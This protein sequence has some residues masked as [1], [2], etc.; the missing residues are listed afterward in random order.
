MSSTL[1]I[2]DQISLTSVVNLVWKL[3]NKRWKTA[4]PF[5]KLVF[6]GWTWTIST[7]IS[8]LVWR[9]ITWL[10]EPAWVRNAP[11]APAPDWMSTLSGCVMAYLK[12]GNLCRRFM[13]ADQPDIVRFPNGLAGGLMRDMIL[14][15]DPVTAREVF[16]EPTTAKPVTAYRVFKRLTGY[17]G[18]GD[19]LSTRSH[20]DPLYARTRVVVYEALMKRTFNCYGT[21]FLDT[22]KDLVSRIKQTDPEKIVVVDEMHR[23]ATSLI[24]RVAFDE[25]SDNLD[26]NLFDSVVWM[27]N[28]IIARPQNNGF[29]LLDKIPTPRNYELHRNQNL[30]VSTIEQM[31]ANKKRQIEK[32]FGANADDVISTL[33]RDKKNT[34]R[35]ILG[36]CSIFFFAGFDTTSNTMAMILYHLAHNRDVQT[37]CRE[38]IK[39]IIGMDRLPQIQEIHQLSYVYAVIRETLRMFP[40]VPM[41]A[42]EVT[43]RHKNGVCPRFK[44]EEAFGVQINIFG[45]HYNPKGW[46]KPTEFIPERWIDPSIDAGMDAQQRVYCP[47]ALGKRACL[48]RHFAFIEILTVL[49]LLLQNFKIE[50]SKYSAPL[51]ITEGATL[52]V[53][54]SL[55]LSFRPLT[56]N[57]EVYSATNNHQTAKYTRKEVACHNSQD[58]A[59]LIIDG[60][61][62]DVTKYVNIQGNGAHPGGNEILIGLAGCDATADFDFISHSKRAIKMLASYKIGVLV[63]E[64]GTPIKEDNTKRTDRPR[65]RVR[66]TVSVHQDTFDDPAPLRNHS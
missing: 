51:K 44:E 33:L 49:T 61:V 28:D 41:V 11:L 7:W 21:A 63:D 19:F 54:R 37:K 64:D 12:P 42:R 24:T 13:R 46:N 14:V 2:S 1:V 53:D 18:T 4:H 31:I 16:T 29:K 36:I 55:L 32:G 50:P 35:D 38:E 9:K 3:I 62:Y 52:T 56:E 26:N 10:R 60:S 47:F 5:T 45:L 27:A 48:G 65:N 39:N 40:I 23:I 6:K 43:Q 34:D 15:K 20:K 8:L 57:R 17:K 66:Q 58:D 25:H 30:L 22:V 59:W